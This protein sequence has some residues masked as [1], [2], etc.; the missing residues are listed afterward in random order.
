MGLLSEIAI[1]AKAG[2]TVAEVK[3][4]MQ[5]GAEPAKNAAQKPQTD[6]E[7]NPEVIVLPEDPKTK[8]DQTP[9]PSGDQSPA[10]SGDQ[11]DDLLLKIADL[12]KQLEA[13]QSANRKQDV[14]KNQKTEQEQLEDLARSFM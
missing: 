11:S 7:Q 14:N 2:Y 8:P 6:L 10:P 5:L 1:L 4:L 13:A 9:T 3:E 12:E